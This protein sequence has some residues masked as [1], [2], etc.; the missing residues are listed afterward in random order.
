ME[1]VWIVHRLSTRRQRSR[2]STTHPPE[3][4]RKAGAIESFYIEKPF[5]APKN[6][7]RAAKTYET[8]T[9]AASVSAAGVS[10]GPGLAGYVAGGRKLRIIRQLGA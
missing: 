4:I 1:R 6:H 10:N 8:L 5:S 7:T 9:A 2:R 3:Q